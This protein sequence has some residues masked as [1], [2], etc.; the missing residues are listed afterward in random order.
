MNFKDVEL[1]RERYSSKLAELSKKRKKIFSIVIA[2]IL[3]IELF[4]LALSFNN[5]VKSFPANQPP[6]IVVPIIMLVAFVLVF[7]L[8]AATVIA[9]IVANN[10]VATEDYSAYK[11]AYKAYFIEKQLANLFTDVKY[12]HDQ[13]LDKKVLESTGL[14]Y[15]G[16]I[17]HS[18][19]LVIAK[20]KNTNFMQA[21]VHIEDVKREKDEDGKVTE[22]IY[23]VFKGR[24]LVFEFPKKFDFK[25]VVSFQGYHGAYINPKT[26]KGL[27]RIETES[28]TFNKHFLVY[29]EDGF[30]AFYILSPTFIENLEKLGQKYDNALALYFSDNKLFIGLNNGNDSFEPPN[31]A[32]PINEQAE[33]TKVIDD[34]KLITEIVENLK[35]DQK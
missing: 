32:T 30:E 34:M 24:Y 8:A 11:K 13:G 23:T 12:H 3:G 9:T 7:D 4:I 29:A 35:L 19:D 14:I 16:D 1:A 21:D 17:Y 31:P 25:M 27:N 6:E 15:T 28:T 26:S 22:H 2:V 18:N 33:Q 10:N 5:I 20:Y